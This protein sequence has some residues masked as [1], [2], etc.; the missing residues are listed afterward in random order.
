MLLP[1]KIRSHVDAVRSRDPAARSDLEVL[2]LYP[3][4][5]A[6]A[7]HRIGNYLWRKNFYFFAR[8]VS[9]FSRWLTGIEIHPGATI[10]NNFFIDHAMG[11]VIGETAEIG[12]NVALYQGVTLGGVAPD[13]E[14]REKRHPTLDDN[15]IIG[16]GA[17]VLGPIT[18]GKGAR[19]GASAVVTN[20]VKPHTTVVGIPAREITTVPIE[21]V[22]VAYG[23]PCDQVSD[24]PS[25]L[26]EC[27][28]IEL[29]GLHKRV[30]EL[31]EAEE[32]EDASANR[33]DIA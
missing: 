27:M 5:H 20:D 22:F 8:W 33:R 4:V 13:R 25:K 28:R 31:E 32:Q 29:A 11:V 15:V 12:N 9:Q 21:P 30:K 26:L 24:D 18:V 23:T 7:L 19:V 17:Q 1:K 6:I 3:S 10:G 14:G 2:L 16:S